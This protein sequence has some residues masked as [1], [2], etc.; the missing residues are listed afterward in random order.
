M[1]ICCIIAGIC[2]LVHNSPIGLKFFAYYLAGASY[3]GQA[4]TF[5]WANE[6]C[7]DDNQERGI[8]LASMNMWNNVINAWWSIV[9]YPATDAPHFTKGMIALI[10]VS[11][12]TLVITFIVLWFANK[13][14]KETGRRS[15]GDHSEKMSV[16]RS[17]A[18][19]N[20]DQT[21]HSTP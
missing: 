9:F 1:A 8:V 16:N 11:V 13:E 4:T 7:F 20:T 2:L 6:I 14:L 17:Q 15:L 3:A 21:K 10:S 18:P 12:A 5:A 19:E